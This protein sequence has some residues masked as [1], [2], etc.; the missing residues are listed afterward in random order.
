MKNIRM[1][2]DFDGS[3]YFGWQRLG[4]NDNTI[5]YK[6][7]TLLS[8]MTSESI[9][10]IGCS[11]TDR[12]VHSIGLV[13][14][15]HTNSSMTVPEI[16][17]YVNCYLP[18]DIV[19]YD[20]KEVDEKFH[21]RYNAISK[22]YRYTI[23]NRKYQ[24]VFTRKFT[25]H[26]PELLD[27]D[28]MAEAASYLVGTFDFSAFTTMKSKKKSSVRTISNINI[29]LENGYIYVEFKGDGFLHNMIRII[30]GTLIRVGIKDIDPKDVQEILQSKT[31]SL[32]GPML[33][34]KGLCLMDVI[35]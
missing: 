2:V 1:K 23:D 8:K 30:V 32:A 33:E 21:S 25:T 9:N 10:V 31:R 14:N 15:F 34:G 24:N 12:G 29:T 13:C 4:D 11:R 3:R 35:Y 20:L 26:I 7:E 19:A 17:E 16:E 27:L 28:L 18:D 22:V 5:Q 6:L